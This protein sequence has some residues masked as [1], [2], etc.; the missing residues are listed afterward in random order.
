MT[1][2]FSIPPAFLALE[3]A[4][5]FD[6]WGA[7]Y[8]ELT[9]AQRERRMRSHMTQVLWWRG[10]EW[11]QPS[12]EIAAFSGDDLLRPGL[13]PFAGDGFGNQ[14][15][16][17]PPWQAGADVPVVFALHDEMTSGLFARDFA[18]CLCRCFLQEFADDDNDESYV[19][20]EALW[21]AHFGIL[22][23]WLT[24]EQT[25]LLE[26]LRANLSA[27]AC[28]EADG[29]IAA[30]IPA[31]RLIAIQ[32]PTRYNH[33]YLDRDELIRAY[34]E[35]IAFFRELVEVEG[36]REFASKLQEALAARAGL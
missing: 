14:Y 25:D 6:Y 36:R 12:V 7:P 34:D 18:E 17:Y 33:Q 32:L 9:D 24:P 10:I 3:R 19:P 2:S 29:M 16:W 15:C 8:R 11:D 27:D 26:R 5:R 22:R 28:K 35:S 20:R 4:G 23:P 1:A 13:I 21:D 31:R 30:R